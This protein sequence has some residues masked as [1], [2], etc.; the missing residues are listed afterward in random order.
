MT[1]IFKGP[2]PDIDI[3]QGTLTPWVLRHTER[4]AGRP[5]LIDGPARAIGKAGVREHPGRNRELRHRRMS[6]DGASCP[7]RRP[8]YRCGY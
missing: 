4:L 2:F 5:A 1:K 6:C 3:P 8:L 7:F